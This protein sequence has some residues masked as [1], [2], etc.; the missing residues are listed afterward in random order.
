MAQNQGPEEVQDFH[1]RDIL[2]VL[3]HVLQLSA[4]QGERGPIVYLPAGALDFVA[5][6]AEVNG[7]TPP[8]GRVRLRFNGTTWEGIDENGT[9]IPI[10]GG[11]GSF[12]P[13]TILVN[14]NGDVLTNGVNVLVSG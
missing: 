8:V 1:L 7:L 12:D 6:P 5:D 3:R 9:I 10:G 11:G 14:Q 4:T 2:G 13:D